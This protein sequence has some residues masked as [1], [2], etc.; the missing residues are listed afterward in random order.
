MS[1]VNMEISLFAKFKEVPQM[2]IVLSHYLLNFWAKF[3]AIHDLNINSYFLICVRKLLIS[4]QL[5][6]KNNLLSLLTDMD[7]H[8][9]I[10]SEYVSKR[11]WYFIIA[12]YIKL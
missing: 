1:R 3:D 8:V 6:Y 7:M 12:A 4:T 11:L 5:S 9:V 10:H 2:C